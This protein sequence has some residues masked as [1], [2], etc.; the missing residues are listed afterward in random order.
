MR[1]LTPFEGIQLQKSLAVK[2]EVK[3]KKEMIGTPPD[4]L[5]RKL[6]KTA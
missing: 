2:P 6:V 5:T 3:Q 4:N 1:D